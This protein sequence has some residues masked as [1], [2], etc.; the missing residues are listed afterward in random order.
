MNKYYV[1]Q[2]TRNTSIG[3]VVRLLKH[4]RKDILARI[5]LNVDLKGNKKNKK[6]LY[7]ETTSNPNIKEGWKKSY[8]KSK[9]HNKSY[10]LR[11]LHENYEALDKVT[12]KEIHFEESNNKDAKYKNLKDE[13]LNKMKSRKRK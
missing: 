7:P 10:N 13:V 12:E 6:P 5:Y 1:V 8:M 2:N 11:Q 9:G 3:D 4:R